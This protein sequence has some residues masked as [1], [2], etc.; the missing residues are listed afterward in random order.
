[1]LWAGTG[2]DTM[3][4]GAGSDFFQFVNGAA[5][6]NDFIT[7]FSSSDVVNLIGYGANAAANAINAATVSGGSSTIQLSDSTKITF[8]NVASLS[9]TNIHNV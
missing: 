6:G 5:G 9:T 3:T 1:M 2:S 4:G 8:V 7:D